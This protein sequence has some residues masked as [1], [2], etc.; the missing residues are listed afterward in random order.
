MG[1]GETRGNG[2]ET[3]PPLPDVYE[4]VRTPWQQGVSNP[5]M[6]GSGWVETADPEGARPRKGPEEVRVRG[7]GAA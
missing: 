2:T 3:I 4:A 1:Y 7:F 5:P 6:Y